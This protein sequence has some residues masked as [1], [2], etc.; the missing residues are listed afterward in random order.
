MQ[1]YEQDHIY[2]LFKKNS[3][4]DRDS[5]KDKTTFTEGQLIKLTLCNGFYF[6]TARKMANSQDTYLMVYPEVFNWEVLSEAGLQGTIVDVDVSSVYALLE[7]YP[8]CVIFT[9]LGGTTLVRG[10]MK[11]L[12]SIDIS[13]VKPYFG[14]MIK[15][16]RFCSLLGRFV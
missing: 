8:D 4:W 12:T 11:L 3:S 9:E 13:W 15:V 10:V 16:V 5:R 2:R 6:N 7:Q 1:H 14:M